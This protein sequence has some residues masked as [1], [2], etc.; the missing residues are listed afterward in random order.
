MSISQ[1]TSENQK[2]RPRPHETVRSGPFCCLGAYRLGE[3][4]SVPPFSSASARVD[5][6]IKSS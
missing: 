6:R 4:R 1:E 2:R 3:G 5:R